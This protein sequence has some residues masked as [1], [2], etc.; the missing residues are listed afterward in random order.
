[1]MY[2]MNKWSCVALS[3]MIL[4]TGE[5]RGFWE[6][7]AKYPQLWSYIIIFSLCSAVGQLFIFMT[8]VSFGPLMCS[9]ITT[10]RKFF[11]VLCSVILF[12]NP[13]TAQQWVATFLVFTGLALDMTYGKKD[14]KKKVEKP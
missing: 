14:T 12:R 4:V 6:F 5:F 10:T 1:M 7:Q 11:T 9:V 8:V 3:L 2:N 13:I